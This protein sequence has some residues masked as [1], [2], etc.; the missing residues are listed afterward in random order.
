LRDL[1]APGS[2]AETLSAH[3]VFMAGLAAWI[4]GAA[5]LALWG[6]TV[7]VAASSGDGSF[8][9]FPKDAELRE[10]REVKRGLKELRGE[11]LGRSH[12]ARGGK[13]VAPSFHPEDEQ[14]DFTRREVCVKMKLD[15]PEK[16]KD[17]DCSKATYNS[18]D[19][20]NWD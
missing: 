12:E 9:I 20:F 10:A 3:E 16:Y 5:V 7:W 11:V 4:S 17:L 6:G 18:P 8:D 1:E 2:L 13:V 14:M 19:P 15:F